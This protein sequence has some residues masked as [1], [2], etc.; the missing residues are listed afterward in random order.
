MRTTPRF[1]GPLLVSLT[2]ALIG[3]GLP[4]PAAQAH[5]VVVVMK[6]NAFSPKTLTE[7]QGETVRWRN[8]DRVRHN[9][10]SKQGFW[11]SPNLASGGTYA[12]T[13]AFKNAGS[14]AYLCTLHGTA[15]SGV[16]KIPVKAIST[17]T[18]GF[19][20]RWS[21]L[22]STPSNR[23]F[24][25]QVLPPGATHWKAFRTDT[26]TRSAGFS[27]SK[28]GTWKVRARTDNRANG[29]SSGWSPAVSLTI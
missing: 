3:V 27:P 8:D 22:S 7:S 12:Q 9:T 6:G 10:V 4:A 28:H 16:V 1:L 19:I 29:K 26:R 11:K 25:V 2:V 24:D 13:A 20:L 17:M 21:S 14:Y 5:H 23:S 15:M 18:G